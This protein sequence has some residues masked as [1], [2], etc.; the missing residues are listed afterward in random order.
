[1]NHCLCLY[2]LVSAGVVQV[3]DW[4]NA[5]KLLNLLSGLKLDPVA[6]PP[7]ARALCGMLRS[8]LQP[9]FNALYPDGPRSLCILNRKVLPCLSV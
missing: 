8:R 6:F 9:S 1:M 5:S 2:L 7:I 4:T 3:D